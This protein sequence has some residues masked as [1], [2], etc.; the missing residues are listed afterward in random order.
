MGKLESTQM[1]ELEHVIDLKGLAA[2]VTALSE[3]CFD[4][5]Q[6]LEENWQETERDSD[7]VKTWKH[8]AQYLDKVSAH[9]WRQSW[10][11]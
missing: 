4:K 7:Q 11:R 6:H 3:I 1:N 8:N 10:E 9:I 5:M 2:V